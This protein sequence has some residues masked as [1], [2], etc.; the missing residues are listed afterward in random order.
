MLKLG[1]TLANLT[2]TAGR[3]IDVLGHDSLDGVDNQQVGT[4]GVDMLENTLC[5]CLTDDE[6]ILRFRTPPLELTQS[7]GSH[8]DLLLTFL[9]ADV[10]KLTVIDGQ[11]SLQ[12]KSALAYAWFAAEQQQTARNDTPPEHAVEF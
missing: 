11:C 4:D 6:Q 12:Q 1:G 9:T 2:H 10:K 5:H 7:V 3:R 8:L